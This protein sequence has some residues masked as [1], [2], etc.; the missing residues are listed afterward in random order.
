MSLIDSFLTGD[1]KVLRRCSG[2]YVNGRYVP[3][4][5][6]EIEVCGSMQ[7]TSARELKLPEEGNRIK[8]YWKFYTDSPILL[9]STSSLADSDKVVI[10]GETYRAMSREQ[11]EG[12]RLDYFMTILWR[13]PEQRSDGV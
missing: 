4:E 7:P 11:W 8:Q 12:T 1:Y 10:N 5:L 13:E 6:E 3:G 9:N 2:Q